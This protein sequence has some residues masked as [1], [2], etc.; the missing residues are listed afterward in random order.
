MKPIELPDTDRIEIAAS[1]GAY[2][3]SYGLDIP[4]ATVADLIADSSETPQ[5]RATDAARFG[6]ILSQGSDLFEVVKFVVE[7]GVLYFHGKEVWHWWFG[8]RQL[9][10]SSPPETEEF[11]GKLRDL[12]DRLRSEAAAT[13]DT[14]Q[15]DSRL[16]SV[17]A[18]EGLLGRSR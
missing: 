2:F 15:K 16:Q 8:S 17:A 4:D 13:S 9:A 5:A 1:V 12:A 10:V 3:R 6:L 7:A 18:I 11:I 14:D